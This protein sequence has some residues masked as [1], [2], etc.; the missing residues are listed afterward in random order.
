MRLPSTLR[1]LFT[2]ETQTY[3]YRPEPLVAV[4]FDRVSY[5]SYTE[6][7]FY[8]GVLFAAVDTMKDL[9]FLV[10]T[11]VFNSLYV[12]TLEF[13]K[14]FIFLFAAIILLIPSEIIW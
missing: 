1:L 12:A 6:F 5:S 11:I 4:V 9:C 13:M 10:A 3:P 7:C 14:G 2:A 8:P